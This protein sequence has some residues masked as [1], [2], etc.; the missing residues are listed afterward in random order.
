VPAPRPDERARLRSDVRL[1]GLSGSLRRASANTA[2]LRAAAEL[3]P[4]GVEVVLHPLDDVPLYHG[5]VEAR[6]GYP[7]GVVALRRA[8]AGADALLLASP[9]YNWSTTAVLKNAID[10]ASRAP[11]APLDGKP[12]A[13]LSAAGGSGGARAQAHLRDI[14]AHNEVDLLDQAVQIPRATRHLE[15]GELAAPEHRRRIAALVAAL[16]VRVLERRE[17]RAA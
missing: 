2:A 17:E 7:P 8:I 5:D 16:A 15:D 3:A 11:D 13:L 14:L 4:D 12:A 6:E 10:W 9:E 1:L